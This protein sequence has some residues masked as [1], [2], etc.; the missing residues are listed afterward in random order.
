MGEFLDA[1]K[2]PGPKV[3]SAGVSQIMVKFSQFN[4]FLPKNNALFHL[5]VAATTTF[6]LNDSKM[7]AQ[8]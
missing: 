3:K 1:S 4:I 2:N 5:L 7:E 8:M 6:L